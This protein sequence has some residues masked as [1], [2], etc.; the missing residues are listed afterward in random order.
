MGHNHRCLMRSLFFFLS[1]KHPLCQSYYYYSARVTTLNNE[2]CSSFVIEFNLKWE[3]IIC[4]FSCATLISLF[5]WSIVREREM[6]EIVVAIFVYDDVIWVVF[7]HAYGV[8]LL[9]FFGKRSEINMIN[10]N[11]NI[12]TDWYL[13][14]V[15]EY[16]IQIV[17]VI[18]SCWNWILSTL[19]FCFEPRERER[20][21]C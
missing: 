5:G 9:I 14:R 10:E 6:M 11:N 20:Y 18:S 2:L 12:G 17:C 7:W 19:L 13:F 15:D 3:M 8:A 4:K 16:S 21:A 1:C